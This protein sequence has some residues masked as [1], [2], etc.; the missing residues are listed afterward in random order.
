MIVAFL[1]S[2]KFL[3]T[4]CYKFVASNFTGSCSPLIFSSF[5]GITS[6]DLPET[7]LVGGISVVIWDMYT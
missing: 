6:G 7:W 5:L 4:D 2:Y 1:M 3:F